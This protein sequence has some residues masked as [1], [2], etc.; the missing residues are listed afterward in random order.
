M[1]CPGESQYY[2][3]G[4]KK[5]DGAVKAMFS[6]VAFSSYLPEAV[7]STLL[8]DDRIAFVLE[9]IKAEISEEME[10]LQAVPP[11]VWAFVESTMGL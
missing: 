5:F 8:V 10:W 3:A 11:A 2:L 1:R 9:P 4:F 7:L 6:V